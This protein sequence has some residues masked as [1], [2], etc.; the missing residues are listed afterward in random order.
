MTAYQ[1]PSEK[2]STLKGKGFFFH[3]IVDPFSEG[4]LSLIFPFIITIDVVFTH[5]NRL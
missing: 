1:T 5:Q 4:I 3:F 2:G